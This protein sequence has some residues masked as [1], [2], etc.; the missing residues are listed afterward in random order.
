MTLPLETDVIDRGS[1][2]DTGDD[3]LQLTT[4]W[5][6]EKNV[7]RHNGLHLEAGGHVRQ[8][9]QPHLVVRPPAKGKG[10]VTPSQN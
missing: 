7:I 6:V 9:V 8:L 1:A 4:R 5:F 2:A 3:V 10:D